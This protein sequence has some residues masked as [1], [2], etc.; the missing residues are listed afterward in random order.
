MA[1]RLVCDYGP[2][3]PHGWPSA[4]GVTIGGH[5]PVHRGRSYHV[6]L[7]APEYA[8]APT[9]EFV[10]TVEAA[11]GTRYAFRYA[12]GLP[13]GGGFRVRSFSVDG[14]RLDLYVVYDGD[15]DPAVTLR[16]IH[17]S[18]GVVDNGGRANPFVPTGGPTSVDGRRLVNLYSTAVV[19]ETST[20]EVFLVHDTGVRDHAGHDCVVVTGGLRYGW[21]VRAVEE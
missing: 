16:W 19:K 20:A 11:F 2:S 10:R 5:T 8:A 7:C 12:G 21:R 4:G 17:V 15:P 9:A 14:S 13:A 1:S 3:E 18:D 6:E